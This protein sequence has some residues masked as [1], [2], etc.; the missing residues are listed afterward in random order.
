MAKGYGP[1]PTGEDLPVR[2]SII[3][4]EA[5]QEDLDTGTP[6]MRQGID[7]GV[8]VGTLVRSTGNGMVLQAG[9]EN[10]QDHSEGLGQ[11]VMIDHGN[12]KI[13]VYGHLDSIF[14]EV[15]QTVIRGQ[16]LGESGSTGRCMGPRVHYHE[17]YGDGAYHAAPAD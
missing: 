16:D 10:D 2:G 5:P 1:G 17:R 12:G 3:T 11:R 4:P 15:G 6:Q 14:L 9:W 7:Y 8:P 13:T